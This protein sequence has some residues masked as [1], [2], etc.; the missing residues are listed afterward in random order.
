MVSWRPAAAQQVPTGDPVAS[1]PFHLGAIGLVPRFSLTNFGIDT[2]VFNQVENR[3][4]DL[5]L[6]ASPGAE[7]FLRTGRGLLSVKGGG[8]IVYFQKFDTERSFNSNVS[9]QYEFPV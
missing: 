6:T 9:G 2:N 3:Q 1:A 8:E 4:R 7:F 5:T